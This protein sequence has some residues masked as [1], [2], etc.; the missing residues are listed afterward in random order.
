[1]IIGRNC[2]SWL[3]HLLP[4]KSFHHH[5]FAIILVSFLVFFLLLVTLFTCDFTGKRGFL[6]GTS[7]ATAASD[8]LSD[9]EQSVLL[10]GKLRMLWVRVLDFFLVIF[11]FVAEMRKK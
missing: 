10:D 4:S 8:A 5:M 1:M 2:S 7:T 6:A 3:S 9:H 11:L